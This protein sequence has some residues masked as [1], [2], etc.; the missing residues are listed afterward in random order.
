MS[1]WDDFV[2]DHPEAATALS[3]LRSY[4][5][6][7]N[8]ITIHYAYFI[9]VCLVTSVIFWGSS[10]PAW[11]ISYTD[12]LFLVVSAMTEAGLN[13]V[14]LS[15]MTT[16]QQVLL[17]LLIIFGSSI[18]VSIWTVLARKHVFEKRFEDIVR[19]ERMRRGS[20]PG[21][22]LGLPLLQRF[23]SFRKAQTT[24]ASAEVLPTTGAKVAAKLLPPV[25]D[26]PGDDAGAGAGNGRPVSRRTSSLPALS[27]IEPPTSAGPA[28]SNTTT[29][30]ADANITSDKNNDALEPPASPAAHIAFVESPR[31]VTGTSTRAALA[32]AAQF[33]QHEHHPM[34]RNGHAKRGEPENEKKDF[35]VRHL[36]AYHSSGRNAQFHDL[37]REEREH[38][39]GC[40]YRALKVLAV[41]VPLYFFLWQALGCIAL[42][43]WINNYQAET[44]L[45]NGIKPWWLG[46]FNGASAFN[47]SG[48]SLL[49][50]NMVPF[51]NSYFVLI[52]MGLMILAGNTAYPI[53]LRLIV[54][55]LLRLLTLATTEKDFCE[56]K[57]TFKFILHYPRRVYTNLFP[58]RQTWWLLFMLVLLNCVDWVSFELLNLGNPV[59]ENIPP[60]SRVLDGLFQALAVRSGGFYVVNISSVYIGLQVLYV[61]MMYISVYPVVITMRHSNVYEERSLGIYADDDS[62][63]QSDSDPEMTGAQEPGNGNGNGAYG[64][65]LSTAPTIG[66]T[67]PSTLGGGPPRATTLARRLSKS[68]TAATFGR[69]LHR[70]FTWHGVGVQP[71]S[72]NNGPESR[73]SF[74][75]QQ[76]HGQ[77]AHDIWW[78]VLAIL[79]IV[80]IETSNFLADPVTFSV[81]N[82]IFEVV[83]AYGCVGIS[84]GLPYAAYSFSGGWHAASKLVLC[85]VMIRGRHRGLPVALDRA[86]RLPGENLHQEEEEDNRI[87]RSMTSRRVSIEG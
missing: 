18:W 71:P 10:D 49:D 67:S 86:V 35:S 45:A 61:I 8:F 54:W 12:S 72:P 56:L 38:L 17:F 15:Q 73:I 22:S 77:L 32:T 20:R 28:S 7:L 5:P 4:L 57:E 30:A 13:T 51:Q 58:A 70:T 76:I 59:I 83:S 55:S 2:D 82:V 66:V 14:N 43:A 41:I 1:R 27:P 69:A 16:W 78:L 26:Q 33:N 64:Q 37:S 25:D 84:V 65:T 63:T 44:P 31:P 47:N 42:G 74:I 52:T 85:A 39:G 62:A 81:F 75:S 9:I 3:K 68:G 6:P 60:G 29:T 80:T 11:S 46:I 36:L 21:S 19:A 48:M 87:R 23:V 53:F 40:E 24:P 50:A 34:R 79:V